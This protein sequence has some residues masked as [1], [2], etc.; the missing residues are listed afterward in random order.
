MVQK[1]IKSN[2]PFVRLWINY[3]VFLLARHK[4]IPRQFS[5]PYLLKGFLISICLCRNGGGKKPMQLVGLKYSL[6]LISGIKML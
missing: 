6:N 1:N 4:K 5:Y 3:K 2:F